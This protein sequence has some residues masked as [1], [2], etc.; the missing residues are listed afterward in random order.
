MPK[1]NGY[2]G[3]LLCVDLYSRRVFTKLL[4]SQRGE[5]QTAAML[6]MFKENGGV[7]PVTMQG[8]G[9][10]DNRVYTDFFK[11]E[12]IR[13]RA[14]YRRN[15]CVIAEINNYKIKCRLHAYCNHTVKKDGP[16]KLALFTK[17]EN[18]TPKPILGGF[19]PFQIKSDADDYLVREVNPNRPRLIP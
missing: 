10:Y 11:K 8:D 13:F 7:K 14:C 18:D 4:T 16:S 12:G 15:K 5:A 1:Y 2:M 3:F 9:E 19:K 17:N 6:K